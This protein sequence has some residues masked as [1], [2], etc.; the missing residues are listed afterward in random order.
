M[1]LLLH[2]SLATEEGFESVKDSF[3]NPLVKL[4]VWAMLSALMYH[5]V[6]G[7]RHLIMDIGIG[8][9]IEGG[10]TGSKIVIAVAVVLIIATGVWI[11]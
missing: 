6:A 7:I 2:H 5:V 1:L 8:E 10:R 9:T 4:V 3:A 11:W